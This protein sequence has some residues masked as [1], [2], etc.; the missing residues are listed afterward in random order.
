MFCQSAPVG[1]TH[2]LGNTLVSCARYIIL[3]LHSIVK[4]FHLSV[5]FIIQFTDNL[6]EF[7]N[8]SENHVRCYFRSK[9]YVIFLRVHSQ[10]WSWTLLFHIWFCSTLTSN[11][12]PRKLGCSKLWPGMVG[13]CKHPNVPT[14][15]YIIVLFFV[16]TNIQRLH[17]TPKY[18]T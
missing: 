8:K 18:I 15:C 11:T 17:K 3:F 16:W 5:K 1:D 6:C 12:A 4:A 14:Y 10:G 13:L 9:F 2:F 7:C